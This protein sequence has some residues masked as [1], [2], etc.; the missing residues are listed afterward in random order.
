MCR[1]SS[2]DKCIYGDKCTRLHLA[3]Q[4]AEN[5]D[6]DDDQGPPSAGGDESMMLLAE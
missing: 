2:R 6:D 3:D 1:Y 5:K 4:E